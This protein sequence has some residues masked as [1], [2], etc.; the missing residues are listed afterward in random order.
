MRLFCL[1]E[2]TYFRQKNPNLFGPKEIEELTKM[3][4]DL[5]KD[6]TTINQEGQNCNLEDYQQFL[7]EFFQKTD[8]EDRHCTVTMKTAHNFRLM[9]A[10]IDVLQSWG[11]ID[12]EMLKCK[13]YCQFKAVDIFKALKKGEVPKRGGPKEQEEGLGNEINELAKNMGDTNLGNNNNYKQNQGMNEQFQNN[14]FGNNQQFGANQPHGK[15]QQ[16][17]QQLQFTVTEFVPNYKQS[18]N[19]DNVIKINELERQ[20]KE[21]K[22]KNQELIFENKNLKEKINKLNKENS[23]IIE[24]KKAINDLNNELNHI[25]DLKQKMENDLAKKDSEMQKLLSQ[26]NKNYYDISDISS[27]KQGDKIIG[28][29]FVSM[30]TNDIGHYNLVCKNG[31]LF[32]RLEER[33]YNDFPYFKNFETFFEVNGK[34][35]KR[36]K[37]VEQNQIKANDIINIFIIEE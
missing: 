22:E 18:N 29:N 6:K 27:L 31:D 33:L 25:K 9:A 24:L 36:F 14:Q 10:F 5:K 1:Q 12:E 37:T 4:M 17:N 8:Y 32:V 30:G 16:S 34:R 35:I 15:N 28:V 11:P 19:D 3:I 7:A 23:Q 20:L 2:L 21:E 26:K 13:K